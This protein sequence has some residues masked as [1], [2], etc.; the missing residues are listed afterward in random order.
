MTE[1]TIDYDYATRLRQGHLDLE[2]LHTWNHEVGEEITPSPVGL[3]MRDIA[4]GRYGEIPDE[5]PMRTMAPRGGE[6]EAVMPDMGYRLNHK[7]EVW[8]DN[9][10]ELYEEAVSRQWSA[11]RDIAWGEIPDLDPDIEHALCQ[12]CTVLS[13]VEMIASDFPAK[14][15]WQINHDYVETKM[16][17]ATQIMDESR[18][19]EVFR[20]RALAKGAGLGRSK[21]ATE[22]FLKLILDAD[23]YS[24]GSALMHLLGEGIVLSL[25]RAG[26][27]IS[28]SHV[29]KKIF[30]LCMQDEARHVAYGTM[31]L[32]YALANDPDKADEYHEY[33]DKGETILAALF[34]I[35]EV[36]EPLMILAAG[37][38]EQAAVLGSQAS[39]MLR[40][41]VIEEYLQRCDRAGIDRRSRIQLPSFNGD[42]ANLADQAEV[43]V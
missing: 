23:T 31:H 5:A 17:L 13:E 34:T 36:V 11:T 16:F 27:L 28:P 7:A 38:E 6:R 42:A 43:G 9:V 32:R 10:M 14:W 35:P 33:L 3:T 41:R 15:M 19:T 8:A 21:A 20:K 4:V 37:G 25:F 12:V 39:E 1:L 29:E 40:D 24:E 2:W 30:R 22:E 18:H 26:E